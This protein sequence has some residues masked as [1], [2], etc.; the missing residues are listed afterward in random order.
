M[1]RID[2]VQLIKET[3][4]KVPAKSD[5]THS[6]FDCDFLLRELEKAGM[7]PPEVR[8]STPMGSRI[9]Y[10]T[11]EWEEDINVDE[12]GYELGEENK[13]SLPKAKI[14]K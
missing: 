12:A 11:H 6:V 4:N 8:V 2:M 13:N 1:K 10:E 3:L 14:L 9:F 7:K 5:G